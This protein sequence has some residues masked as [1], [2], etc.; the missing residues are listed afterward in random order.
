MNAGR[1][2]S[3]GDP[4]CL[5]SNL[6]SGKTRSAAYLLLTTPTNCC[7]SARVRRL[8]ADNLFSTVIHQ[9]RQAFVNRCVGQALTKYISASRLVAGHELS[10]SG[11]N[12]T[13]RAR[14]VLPHYAYGN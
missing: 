12:W 3:N 5:S 10:P 8:D 2:T 1:P 7:T 11:Q 14:I 13:A 9:H 6:D 4:E